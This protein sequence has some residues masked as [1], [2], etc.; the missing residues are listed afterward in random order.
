MSEP[1]RFLVLGAK[2]LVGE[3]V[4]R[5]IVARGGEAIALTRGE[6]PAD[7][8]GVQWRALDSLDS[9]AGAGIGQA[10]CVAH[11]WVVAEHVP[12]MRA[13]GVEHLVALSTTSLFTKK[14]SHDAHEQEAW[15]LFEASEAE[16]THTCRTH[17]IG[18][19]ILRPTLIYGNGRDKNVS[20]I[21]AMIRRFKMF[22]LFGAAS[23]KRQ[24]IHARDVAA[25]SVLA[26]QS[27]TAIGKTYNISGGETL[28]YREMV[29]RIFD[30]LGSRAITPTVPLAAFRL[31]LRAMRVIPRF[32]QWTP[33]MAMRM[34]ADQ[35]F[36]HSDAARDFGFA[37]GPFDLAPQDVGA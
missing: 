16:V 37:P 3:E 9:L 29:R 5:Q 2:S 35:A 33:D 36:D 25:A 32:R 23:G 28:T 20:E 18:C 13:A 8:D 11:I 1:A 6:L 27:V 21:A 34:N 31:A 22:P 4:L 15:R 17:D 10:I 7:T 12:A 19:T 14:T 30:A 24:P 26:S